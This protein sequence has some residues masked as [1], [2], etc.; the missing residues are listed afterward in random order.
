MR[1]RILTQVYSDF[2]TLNFGLIN[3]NGTYGR[4]A[5]FARDQ[6]EASTVPGADYALIVNS[7]LGQRPIIMGAHIAKC[8]NDIADF[9]QSNRGVIHIGCKDLALNDIGQIRHKNKVTHSPAW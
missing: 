2:V 3:R 7:S 1:N 8:V 9:G 5:G 4:K 6:I